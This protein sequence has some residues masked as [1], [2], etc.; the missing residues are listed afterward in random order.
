MSTAAAPPEWI[1]YRR[2]NGSLGVLPA[3]PRG[4][5]SVAA[6]QK[7]GG[8]VVYRSAHRTGQEALDAARR[9]MRA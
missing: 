5:A 4:L 7:A 3:S 1:V 6:C 9:K 8:R 2:R